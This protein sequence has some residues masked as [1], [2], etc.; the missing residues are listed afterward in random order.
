MAW[1]RKK[2][3]QITR[4]AGPLYIHE[5][6]DPAVFLEQLRGEQIRLGDEFSLFAG[7]DDDSIY[8]SYQHAGSW[9]NRLIHGDS[10]QIMSSLATKE[11]MVG[12]VQMVYF[13]PPYGISFQSTMQVNTKNRSNPVNVKGISADPEM[14]RVFRDTYQRGIHDYL[15]GIRENVILA[16]DLLADS[17]SIYLQ[18]GAKNV[19]RI[20]VILDEV[21][22]EENRVATI[23][24]HKKGS[25]S[26]IYLSEV[27][28]Y[29]LWYAK[30][31]KNLKFHQLY[32]PHSDKS[33]VLNAMS[34]YAMIEESDGTCRTLTRKETEDP[35]SIGQ[36]RKLVLRSRL[37]SQHWSTTGRSE[38]F[39]W[40]GKEWKCRPTEQWRVSREG[41]ERLAAKDR[42]VAAAKA[43]E[44]G[45]GWKIY[46]DEMPGTKLN[47]VWHDQ[48]T[49]TDMHY[50]VETA[51]KVVERCML[52]S[53]DP[54][55]LVLDITCGSGTTPL[56][57]DKWG[58]RWIATDA[59]RVP[60]ALARQRVLTAIHDWFVLTSSHEGNLHEKTFAMKFGSPEMKG[61]PTTT[62]SK[63]PAVGFVYDRIPYVSAAQ[64]A[65]DWP[66]KYTF[67]VNQP[68]KSNERKSRLASTFTVES[69]SPYRTVSAD[70]Y[71]NTNASE[72]SLE[73]LT[74]ALVKAG[75]RLQNGS[76][77]KFMDIEPIDPETGRSIVSH[78]CRTR[79]DEPTSTEM[80]TTAL[81][82]LPDDAT[83]SQS[84]VREA[85]RIAA[86]D[87]SIERVVILAFNF[88]SD[89]LTEAP[90]QKGRIQVYC[91]R[92]NR[93]L[94]IETLQNT[95]Y[96]QAFVQIGEPEIQVK[97]VDD[98]I[99]QKFTVEVKGFDT[100]DPVS[101][102]LN[103]GKP[104]D[105]D[106]WMLDTNYDQNAFLARKVH[107]PNSVDERQL[108]RFKKS[109]SRHISD[110]EWDSMLSLKSSPFN[111]PETGKI[112]VRIITT[113]AVEMTKVHEFD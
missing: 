81:S 20:S 106:C 109:L 68:I 88:E 37:Q 31:R 17:G 61:G 12:K 57:A 94:T 66:P 53:T 40:N 14:M 1:E 21:Y 83:A 47:N 25:S 108:K 98:A 73:T 63:D 28:D 112:A 18:I 56:V 6:I 34:G 79:L 90:L 100:F 78:V 27:A 103:G 95:A 105:I 48:S 84:W 99:G 39:H 23:T 85:T 104:Q 54:G 5:K 58:R 82:I 111:K 15:D 13:D 4:K 10:G 107:F 55:D 87:P 110:E 60:I 70:V 86:G 92:A 71:P 33:E 3:D 52:M 9:S 35:E 101:G 8:E 43:R 2:P 32:L 102:N 26:S 67:L 41:L 62:D 22:G 72:Q 64:L 75:A 24:F 96:D 77:M 59:S 65:Y 51:E 16:R 97:R 80:Q 74:D 50:V 7:L 93:D 45:L 36:G 113:T 49:A 19:H 44:Y 29:I 11:D 38:S 89:A 76:L 46:E 91:F 69:H 30:D 42:L